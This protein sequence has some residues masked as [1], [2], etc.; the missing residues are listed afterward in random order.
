MDVSL[1]LIDFVNQDGTGTCYEVRSGRV[2]LPFRVRTGRNRPIRLGSDRVRVGAEVTGASIEI[3][4]HVGCDPVDYWEPVGG[5]AVDMQV[6]YRGITPEPG[7]LGL[8]NLVLPTGWHFQRLEVENLNYAGQ[9][10][11]IVRDDA[12]KREALRLLFRGVTV[13]FRITARIGVDEIEP[14]WRLGSVES[15]TIVEPDLE[16]LGTV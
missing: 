12:T 3:R 11:T 14:P 7:S 16:S 8:Y 2:G 15:A 4:C 10:H 13:G 6:A 5:R 1:L 9:S